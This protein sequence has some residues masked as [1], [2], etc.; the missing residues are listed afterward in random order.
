[1][2]HRAEMSQS[3]NAVCIV[4]G[5]R[6]PFLR[7]FTDFRHATPYQLLRQVLI[8][9]VEQ[10]KISNAD[11]DHVCAGNVMQD[12]NTSN[13][14]RDAL[15][16]ANYPLKTTAHTVSMACI[17][18]NMAITSCWEKIKLGHSNVAIGSGVEV[19]SDPPVKYA[20]S[21]RQKIAKLKPPSDIYLLMRALRVFAN[22]KIFMPEAPGLVEFST[23]ETMGMSAERLASMFLVSRQEQ[24]H[25]AIKSHENAF[26]AFEAGLLSD[27]VEVDLDYKI[28]KSDN[29]IRVTNYEKLRSLSPAFHKPNGS[30]T[31]GNA[32]FPTDGASA[33][34]LMS[35]EKAKQL[36]V[37]PKAIL[38]DSIF[39]AC[40]PKDE[41]L[42]GPAYAIA[43]LLKKHN[44][45]LDDI[46]VFEIHEAF[47]GQILSVL[48]AL[49][50]EKFCSE[51]LGLRKKVGL[52]PD[53]KLNSW[54]GTLALG[55][56]LAA[57][58][59]RLVNMAVNR[60]NFEGKKLA[61]VAACAAGAQANAMLIENYS[62]SPAINPGKKPQK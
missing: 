16:G 57:S 43:N 60:L 8:K 10:T 54:G 51:K 46:D 24:D 28:F 56:P 7:S 3:R 34:M 59:S 6:T 47:A 27:V 42:L 21:M 58:G 4:G 12:M 22:P 36:K 13:V 48:K 31:A 9:I 55:H 11:I 41:L 38:V 17:S 52:I 1:L 29:G 25:F 30:I 15:I 26:K 32:S 33:T 50:S 14:A 40:D 2:L 18:S 39:A 20:R 53:T 49:D 19:M 62:P 5:V 45:K 23:Q 44:L 37:T 35:E 61:V